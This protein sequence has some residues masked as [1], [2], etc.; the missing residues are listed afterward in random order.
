MRRSPATQ[1]E[2]ELNWKREDGQRED[3]CKCKAR[4]LVF[5]DVPRCLAEPPD[6][7]L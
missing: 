7:A 5:Q 3:E 1:Y 6:I 4:E 2:N